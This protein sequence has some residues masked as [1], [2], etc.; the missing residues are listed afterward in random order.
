MAGRTEG[1]EEETGG[2]RAQGLR[3]MVGTLALLKRQELRDSCEHALLLAAG[4]LLAMQVPRPHPYG[5]SGGPG[6]GQEICRS[7]QENSRSLPEYPQLFW[8]EILEFKGSNVKIVF[9]RHSHS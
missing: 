3:A 4:A 6:C 1:N 5:A 8:V 7:H 9:P 2:A